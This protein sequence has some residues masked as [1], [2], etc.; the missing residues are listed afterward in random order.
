[1]NPNRE[2]E[3]ELFVAA[4]YKFYTDMIVRTCAEVHK[5]K[6]STAALGSFTHEKFVQS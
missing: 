4:R 2:Y 3:S 5:T 6:T 1:M